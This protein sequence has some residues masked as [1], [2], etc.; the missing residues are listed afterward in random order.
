GGD[1]SGPAL[2]RSGVR[3]GQRTGPPLHLRQ[4][5]NLPGL[6]PHRPGLRGGRGRPGCHQQARR[7]PG[8]RGPGGGAAARAGRAGQRGGL[9][10]PVVSQ[11]AG[12]SPQPAPPLLTPPARHHG[13]R[14]AGVCRCPGRRLLRV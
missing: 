7:R 5:A 6:D 3:R 11:R 9:L 13:H 10:D 1:R 2:A 8:H 14:G 4:R 12:P